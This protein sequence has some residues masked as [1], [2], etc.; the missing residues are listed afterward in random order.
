MVDIQRGLEKQ[1]AAAG[2]GPSGPLARV[3]VAVE[4]VGLGLALL[5]GPQDPR[6]RREEALLLGLSLVE[7]LLRGLQS[8]LV[9]DSGPDLNYIQLLL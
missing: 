1:K 3:D 2:G 9:D 8:L 6:R 7:D 5:G 4:R